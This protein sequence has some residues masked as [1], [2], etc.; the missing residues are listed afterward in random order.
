M[1]ARTFAAWVEPVATQL[2]ADRAQVVAFARSTPPDVWDTP[3]PVDGWT[4][5]DLLAHIGGGNDGMFQKV[6]RAVVARTPVEASIFSVD[7]DAENAREVTARRGWPVEKVIAE[8]E[9]TGEEIQELLAGL[10]DDDRDLRA[11]GS[12]ITLGQFM[13]IV[14]EERHDLEH[15]ERLRM[16]LELPL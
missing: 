10:R 7:T 4:C 15:L 11:E 16:S 12:P 5:K 6:L 1:T 2:R 3:S 9:S 13:D 14:R 8:L